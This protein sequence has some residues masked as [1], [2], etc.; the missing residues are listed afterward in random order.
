MLS[1]RI[2]HDGPASAWWLYWVARLWLKITGW[3]V[4]GE[5][6]RGGRG[7]VIAAP[8]TSNWDLVFMLAVA[9]TFRARLHWLGKHTLFK[10]GFG[11]LM[12]WLG[13]ISIDRRIRGGV[14]AQAAARLKTPEGMSLAVAPAGTRSQAKH[15]KSGFYQIARA[16][17]V[18]IICGFLDYGRKVGGIGPSVV[19][20]GDARADMDQLRAFYAGMQGKLPERSTPILLEEEGVPDPGTA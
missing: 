16:A 4:A 19:P 20:T 11:P 7:V 14:V 13:G 12:R 18:P 9:W 2:T 1:S 8:H 17:N 10:G 3:Q 5:M 6:P 15:W